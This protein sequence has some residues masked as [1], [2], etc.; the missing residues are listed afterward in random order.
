[1]VSGDLAVQPPSECRSSSDR[2][3]FHYA[4][5]RPTL[6]VG[7]W[8][9]PQLPTTMSR[10][11]E[12]CSA[13]PSSRHVRARRRSHSQPYAPDRRPG[14]GEGPFKR[15]IIRGATVIDGTG[16]PPIGPVDIVIEGNRIA[17][18]RSVGYPESRHRS[19]AAGP[20][21]ADEGDR[22]LED[23]RPA[24]LRRHARHIGGTE[25]GTTAEYVFKLWL[26]HGITTVRDPGSGNG[27][28]WTMH[29]RDRSAKNE[30]V[31]PRIVPYA[32]TGAAM[33]DGG[34]IDSPEQ[35]RKFVQWVAKNGGAGLKIIG[36]RRSR[37]RPRH[38]RRAASTRRRSSKLGTTSTSR[39]WASRG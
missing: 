36:A 11:A 15:L 6:A 22:R 17:E 13:V 8:R 24:R 7:S 14:E 21:D 10:H 38:P 1:M 23:V 27:L 4:P 39:R 2:N 28:D 26:A 3:R 29:E 31:A 25:Q 33:W 35:A 12:A 16:A 18:I 5:D 30:I 19:G 37:L 9:E 20:K 32:F 34:A